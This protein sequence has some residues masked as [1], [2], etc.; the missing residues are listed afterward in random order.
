MN[1][2]TSVGSKRGLAVW[3]GEAGQT[4]HE[5]RKKKVHCFYFFFLPR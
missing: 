3:L 2:Y 5:D 4:T 1:T